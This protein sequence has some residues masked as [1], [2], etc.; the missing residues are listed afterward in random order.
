MRPRV[1][2]DIRD[3]LMVLR[4]ERRRHNWRAF[5]EALLILGGI[6]LAM[7]VWVWLAANGGPQ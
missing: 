6:G 1:E 3:H 2:I 5:G 4:T 7:W